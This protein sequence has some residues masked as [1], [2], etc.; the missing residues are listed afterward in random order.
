MPCSES[1]DGLDQVELDT[2]G[3]PVA[4]EVDGHREGKHAH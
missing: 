2:E 1:V 4:A 3:K